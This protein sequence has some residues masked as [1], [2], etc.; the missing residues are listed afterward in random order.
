MSKPEFT[1][2]ERQALWDACQTARASALAADS[3]AARALA[4]VDD[5]HRLLRTLREAAAAARTAAREAH[6]ACEALGIHTAMPPH[7]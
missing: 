7:F 2:L 5:A 6:A 1:D 3:H 4:L